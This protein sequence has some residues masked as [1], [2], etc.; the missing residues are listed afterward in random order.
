M[1]IGFWKHANHDAVYAT[2]SNGTKQWLTDQ[3]MLNGAMQLAAI[4]GVPQNVNVTDDGGLF[5]AIGVILPGTP[6]PPGCDQ[7]GNP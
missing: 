5:A 4:N 1:M 3:G 6:V 7:W 2:Y